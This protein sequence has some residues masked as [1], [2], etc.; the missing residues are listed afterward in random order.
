[1]MKYYSY[2]DCRQDVHGPTGD[3]NAEAAFSE[4]TLAIPDPLKIFSETAIGV[5]GHED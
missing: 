1:M 4:V 5:E 3:R 2:R